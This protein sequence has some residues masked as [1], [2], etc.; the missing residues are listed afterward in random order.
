MAHATG[1]LHDNSIMPWGMH[2]G[3]K[4][5]NVPARYLIY[6]YNNGCSDPFVKAYIA[7]N[8]DVLQTEVKNFTIYQKYSR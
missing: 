7:E 8:L 4:M 1:P 2:K 5:A 6:L 3:K